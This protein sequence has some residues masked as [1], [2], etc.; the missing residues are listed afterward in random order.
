MSVPAG[1]AGDPLAFHGVVAGYHVLYDSGE[2]MADVR[3]AVGCRRAVI[4]HIDRAILAGLNALFEDPVVFPELFDLFFLLD[5]VAVG[6][7]LFVHIF[8]L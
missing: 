3:L 6:T 5:E 4:E 2:D 7:Y 1:L 8:L